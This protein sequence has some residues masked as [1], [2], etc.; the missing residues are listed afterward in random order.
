[1]IK[2]IVDG[3]SVEV[4]EGSMILQAIQQAG[5]YVP[6]LCNHIS[7]QP[8]GACRFCMVEIVQNGRTRFEASCSMPVSNGM[9]IKTDTEKVKK[10]RRLLVELALARSP[11]S[12]AIKKIAAELGITQSRF[13][14]PYNL[15]ARTSKIVG[16]ECILCG[17][18]VR[19]CDDVMGIAAIG[20]EGRGNSRR[21]TTPFDELSDK[22]LGCG[23]CENICPTKSIKMPY[24]LTGNK[25]EHIPS[26]FDMELRG[27]KPIY[28]LY[29]QAVPR[30]PAIDDRYCI[31]FRTNGCK[32]CEDSCEA[33]AINH[34]LPKE[35]DISFSV[36]SIV[37]APGYEL[38]NA[39]NVKELGYDRFD[40]VIT[41]LEFERMLSATGPTSGVI[42]RPSAFLN[43]NSPKSNSKELNSPECVCKPQNSISGS[44][45]SH[46]DQHPKKIAFIQCVGS[47]TVDNNY[48][49]S[50]CC[51]YATKEAIIAKEHQP[52][53]ECC[54]FYID[55][56]AFG[57]GYE[58]YFN[59]AKELGIRFVRCRP[60]FLM[61]DQV[62]KEIIIK[63]V[64]D[65][66]P[67]EERFDL[68][69]LSCGLTP[70][71][72]VI[73]LSKTLGIELNELNFCKTSVF[74]PV[75]SSREGIFVCGPFTEPKDIPETVMQASA[76]AARVQSLLYDRK[77]SETAKKEYPEER[78]VKFEEPRIGVFVCHCG[79]NIGGV[80]D[81]S[82]LAKYAGTLG[83]VVYSTDKVYTCSQDSIAS[84]IE[85]I[86]R[87]RLNRVV[88]AACTPRTH[89]PLFRESLRQA[90]INQYLFEFAN[91]RD[92]CTWVH[93]KEPE[94]AFAKAKDLIRMAV[95]KA[96][97]LE[98]LYEQEVNIEKSA[99]IIGGGMS[100]MTS[101]LE[102]ARQGFVV[103]I[104]EKED[105]LG[106]IF[107]RVHYLLGREDPQKRLNQIIEEVKSNNKIKVYYKSKIESVNGSIGRYET[108]IRL[109][110]G[111]ST[112]IKHGVIIV[113]TGALEFT[114]TEYH[115]KESPN[116]MT[117]LE[118]EDIIYKGS[119]SARNVVMINC[120]NSRDNNHPYCS[121][122][123][124]SHAIKN[125][126]KIKEISPDTNV[127][128]L[129]RDIRAYGFKEKYYREAREKGVIFIRYEEDKKPDVT[130]KPEGIVVNVFDPLL[131]FN[132]ELKTDIL[133]LSTATVP[134]PDTEEIAKILK[135]PL[136]SDKFYLEAHL[137]LRP[138]DFA[139]DGI[140]IAGLAH[141]P[142][143]IDESIIQATASAA[144][145]STVLSKDNIVLSAAISEVIDEACDG[146][147]YCIEPCPYKALTL[148]E[149]VHK[150]S[151]KKT[152]ESNPSICKGCGVCQATC[153][154]RG[155][156]VNHFKL[157]QLS[158]MVDALLMEG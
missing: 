75:D 99:L 158:A 89:E 33:K 95:A 140:F 46:I 24:R 70:T 66:R 5:S 69:V 31:N 137:K 109:G 2:V 85:A 28:I 56:R 127:Y 57:K 50:V 79:K 103:H 51:M 52:D 9:E 68:T 3:K 27:R 35:E 151:I 32:I 124:C 88:V 108:V 38:F 141:S 114:P 129:Y 59:R 112:T 128:I 55:M 133:V 82:A 131:K 154:K 96:R 111:R 40:N 156:R 54:I 117:Q 7:L 138:V 1:M 147:A 97:L 36:G 115:Y 107:R 53:L 110:D 134:Q 94:E 17:L 90:G 77:W 15:G 145:A 157:D 47:R 13:K 113:A 12:E 139:S 120:V 73:S 58:A 20:F 121:R 62:T 78:D 65:G 76:A 16:E 102:L 150:G 44:E 144:R 155:I 72:D 125:A 126:L 64:E 84:I 18:C 48:C 30:V 136:N 22:C 92:Q 86:K 61:E 98:P 21:I 130:L 19:I 118:L 6:T 81:S 104:V 143:N 29:P 146:C 142:K 132:I 34:S 45:T 123:C 41:S 152:V 8:Y 11:H 71:S 135:V 43:N 39:N 119:F 122:I 74:S 80:I 26:E 105:E 148:I 42:L 106:G 101:A 60:S 63:Y 149:Y 100:G 153:P 67:K 83:S 91:I 87:E 14:R 23:A 4:K 25:P 93:Q 10:T 116:I 49:S 37:V